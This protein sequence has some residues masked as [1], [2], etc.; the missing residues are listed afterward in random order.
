M[1]I[2]ILELIFPKK[3]LITAVL[4]IDNEKIFSIINLEI[5]KWKIYQYSV[6]KYMFIQVV[7][8]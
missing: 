3:I 5:I 1:A 8:K 6:K 4:E 7:P 2:R